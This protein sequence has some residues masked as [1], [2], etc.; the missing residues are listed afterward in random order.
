LI[1]CNLDWSL[2]EKIF[3]GE[4]RIESRWYMSRTAPWDRVKAGDRVYFKNSGEPVTISADVKKV[5]QFSNLDSARVKSIIYEY[6]V[7]DGIAQED[8][9]KFFEMFKEKKYCI[10][11][12]LKNSK[13]VEPFDI[14]KSGFGSMSAWISVDD[15]SKIKK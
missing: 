4:K 7:A 12:F 11:I 5:L 9:Q 8:F 10:L 1:N 2:T 3:T 14:N 15:V 13:R 6:G